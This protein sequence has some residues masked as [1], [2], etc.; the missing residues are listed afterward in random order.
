MPIKTLHLTNSWHETSGGIAT[1]YRALIAQA[2]RRGREIRLVVPGAEDRVEQIGGSARIYHVQ[3][4]PARLNSSYRTIYPAKFLSHG[5]RLQE[6][7]A[8]ERPDLVEICDKYTLNYFGGLLRMG[9]LAGC[10]FRPLVVGLSCERMDDNFRSYLGHFPFSQWFCRWYMRWIYFPLFDHHI[11]N[12]D[13]T[14]AEL[15]T[16]ATGHIV[17]RSTWIRPMGVELSHLSPA[18]RSPQMRSRL[19]QNFGAPQ[20]AVLLLYVGRLVPEKNLGLLFE[21]LESL[22]Q[23]SSRDFRL[24]VV[25]DG[26]ERAHWEREC[27][28]R[29]RGKV[30]F[31]GH[32]SDAKVLAGFYANC[33]LFVHPNPREPFGIAPLEAMASGLP[34]VAPNRGGITA[35]ANEGNAWTADANVHD[36]SRAIAEALGNEAMRRRKVEC[37]LQTARQYGWDRVADSFFELYDQLHLFGGKPDRLAGEFSS[38]PASPFRKFLIDQVSR[39]A[40]SVFVR[41][42]KRPARPHEKSTRRRPGAFGRRAVS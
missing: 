4:S 15:R 24:L 16:A 10:N 12:S 30:M 11:A 3:S 31:A 41:L 22:A 25:G 19:L 33:D 13:Y 36:F 8:A 34:L 21:V 35:Y 2:N 32:V 26:I 23:N 28:S 27:A 37:A 29:V 17:P 1:F 42:S 14:A 39:S 18:L 7:V 20:D 5:S 40:R 6:I 9:L 38:S